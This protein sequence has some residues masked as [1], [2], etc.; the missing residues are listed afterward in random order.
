M[1]GTGITSVPPDR[2]EHV[3]E[4]AKSNQDTWIAGYGGVCYCRG[5]REVTPTL[6]TRHNGRRTTQCRSDTFC[7]KTK[8]L[9]HLP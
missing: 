1:R 2:I 7:A 8:D 5:Q 4:W 3:K 9:R 6:A